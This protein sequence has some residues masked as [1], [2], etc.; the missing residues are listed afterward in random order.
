MLRQLKIT[1]P[2]LATCQERVYALLRTIGRPDLALN[3]HELPVMVA[4]TRKSLWGCYQTYSQA[5]GLGRIV[6]CCPAPERQDTLLHEYAHA[7]V[8]W[9][10]THEDDD[11]GP[12]FN[13]WLSQ[14]GG[15]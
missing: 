1:D 15:K 11:H 8:Q 3:V 13:W 2:L 7:L 5:N 4:R 14:L 12:R 10:N 6:L 9:T